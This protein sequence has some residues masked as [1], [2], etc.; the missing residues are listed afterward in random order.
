MRSGEKW[1]ATSE[2]AR[3]QQALGERARTLV[4]FA[5][6]RFC[7]MHS[8]EAA[9]VRTMKARK[10]L[11]HAALVLEVARQLQL[12]SPAPKLIK[13]AIE[14]LIAREYLERAGSEYKYLA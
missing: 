3:K 13:E 9:I 4:H 11:E 5:H 2:C 12:F 6:V 7:R 14:D 10:T 1:P 8:I